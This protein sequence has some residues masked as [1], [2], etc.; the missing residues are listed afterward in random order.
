MRVQSA[1][2]AIGDVV[3]TSHA[4]TTYTYPPTTTAEFNASPFCNVRPAEGD[5]ALH[6]G[7]IGVVIG[8]STENVGTVGSDVLVQFG[9]VCKAKVTAT[10]AVSRGTRLLVSDT[11]GAFD[12]AT[13]Q[14]TGTNVAAVALEA[15]ASGTAQIQ[16]LVT[17][18]L[19]TSTFI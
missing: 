5:E 2:V 10:S 1:T 14:A 12:P 16:V 8:L 11:A 17:S 6:N 4:H 3:V 9:G 7:F 15:L 18:N 13:A 19:W